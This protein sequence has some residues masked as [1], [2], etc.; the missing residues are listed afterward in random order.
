[1]LCGR[2]GHNF[3]FTNIFVTHLIVFMCNSY[4]NTIKIKGKK[5]MY[6]K[7][8]VSLCYMFQPAAFIRD[9]YPFMKCCQISK[10]CPSSIFQGGYMIPN[11]GC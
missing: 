8:A 6:L 1:V 3:H 10:T 5:Q 9:F 4:K 2:Q 7:L 11:G